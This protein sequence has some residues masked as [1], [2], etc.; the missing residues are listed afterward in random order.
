MYHHAFLFR[1]VYQYS[2]QY[3]VLVLLLMFSTTI[4]LRLLYYY[5][6]AHLFVGHLQTHMA[7]KNKLLGHKPS[8]LEVC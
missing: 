5:S 8:F 2:A 3:F 4:F 7:F 6:Y 1:E